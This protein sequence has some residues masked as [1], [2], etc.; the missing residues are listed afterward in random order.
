MIFLNQLTIENLQL[1]G[2]KSQS[3]ID[4]IVHP[5]LPPM[6]RAQP[7]LR[8]LHFFTKEGDEEK[9]ERKLARLGVDD[10]E[11]EAEQEEEEETV[12]PAPA[13]PQIAST[14]GFA[15]FA[16]PSTRE[17]ASSASVATTAPVVPVAAPIAAPSVAPPPSPALIPAS[18]SAPAATPAVD[19]IP[20]QLEQTTSTTTS[21]S[22]IS[23]TSNSTLAT[24]TS[25]TNETVV[26]QT[27][28]MEK[29]EV[30]DEDEGIPELDS[31]SDDGLLEDDDE[32]KED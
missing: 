17:V 11:I 18:T 9:K 30:D 16:L 20:S 21:S 12:R 15:S 6:L 2:H 13:P 14:T 27:T 32:E 22:F 3:S 7:A 8:E 31:G 1:Q 24:T 26:K 25:K 5:K 4:K 19:P 23:F 29:M 28:Q 10:E